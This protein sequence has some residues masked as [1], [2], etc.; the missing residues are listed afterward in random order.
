MK[1]DPHK[2]TWNSQTDVKEKI[3]KVSREKKKK[4]RVKNLLLEPLATALE[5]RRQ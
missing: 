3:L 2:G 1:V 5:T 4:S